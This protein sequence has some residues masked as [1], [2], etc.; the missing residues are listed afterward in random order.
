MNLGKSHRVRPG[1]RAATEVMRLVYLQN[2]S[3]DLR[4]VCKDTKHVAIAKRDPDYK[5]NCLRILTPFRRLQQYFSIVC[6]IV[7]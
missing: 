1:N 5:E 7:M 3:I 2:V 4:S 6:R